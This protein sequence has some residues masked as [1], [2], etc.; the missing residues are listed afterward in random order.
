VTGR[1]V[2]PR[3]ARCVQDWA[4]SVFKVLAPWRGARR[5]GAILS[6]TALPVIGFVIVA[7]VPPRR[8]TRDVGNQEPRLG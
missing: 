8:G 5:T 7:A 2:R 3:R 4:D 6:L 1:P